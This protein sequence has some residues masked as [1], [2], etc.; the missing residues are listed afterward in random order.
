L[1]IAV[2][3]GNLAIVK[4]L[5]ENGANPNA[6]LITQHVDLSKSAHDADTLAREVFTTELRF[7]GQ[8]PS[9]MLQI[10]KTTPL[11]DAVKK[12]MKDVVQLILDY[13]PD[14]VLT[15][16]NGMTALDHAKNL[17]Y[18]DIETLLTTY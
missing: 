9:G 18:K 3:N 11:I 16:E 2:K 7:Y 8:V 15:D 12:N 5:L 6:K 10:E 13:N 4:I 14:L 1:G 17:G